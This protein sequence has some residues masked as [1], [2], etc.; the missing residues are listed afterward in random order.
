MKQFQPVS[1]KEIH[2]FSRISLENYK[3]WVEVEIHKQIERSTEVHSFANKQKGIVI[4]SPLIIIQTFKKDT[5]NWNS[6]SSNV[7]I[8]SFVQTLD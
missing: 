6:N 1:Q 3:P 8:Q 7:V 4:K 5:S 2:G